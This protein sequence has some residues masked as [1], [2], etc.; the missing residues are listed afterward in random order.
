[1][2]LS[3]L[4]LV[5]SFLISAPALRAQIS[6]GDLSVAHANLEGISN[7]TQCHILG[8]K[9]SADKCLKCHTEIKE[10]IS[11]KKGYHASAD[12]NGKECFNCH[13][14]HNGRNFKLI[15]FDTQKFDHN[16]TGY[17]LSVPHSKKQCKDCHT[18][19]YITDL[20]I[21]EKKDSYLGLG[22]TCLNC[23]EDY[24]LKTLPDACLNCHVPDFFVP[25]SRFSHDNAK[26]ILAGKHKSVECAKCHKVETINDKKF[27]QFRGIQYTNCTSCHKDPHQGQFGQN[28]RQCHSEESF[29]LVQGM[30][31]FDHNKTNYK[32]EDKHLIVTC[33]SCHKTKF[34]DPLKH[35]HCTDCHTDYHNGQLTKNG[36]SPDCSQCHSLKGFTLFSFTVDQH[37]QGRFVLKGAHLAIP[38]FECHRKQE[39]WAFR[40][41]GMKCADCHKDI[42]Q[43][44]IQPKYYS[45][46][47][48]I[49]C[50]SEAS[51]SE[52]KFDHSVTD[53]RLTG[54]HVNVSC[55][56][57]HIKREA[58]Q[59]M[60]QK[61][62]G[63]LKSCSGCHKDNHFDQFEKNGTTSCE[64]CHD[65][66][67]W[68]ASKFDHS[69]TNFK[70]D[71][72]HIGVPCAKCHK[73]QQN[74]ENRYVLYKIKEY[75]CESCHS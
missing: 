56:S 33:K 13:S 48:C 24:H 59:P 25:A 68:K 73:E 27:Q 14:E 7:C 60:I 26:F 32:L 21:K 37:N 5:F 2:R 49:T 12:V 3:N 19:K 45:A 47:G 58:E 30:K 6:P 11:Q 66:G 8:D 9:V 69:K 29:Q 28:C 63:L 44:Y 38:C 40:D 31:D 62:T 42:H 61:F 57:C 65:T 10:R 50:H 1:M 43:A 67:N 64:D 22:T 4:L 55:A 75:K 39:K 18:P 74:G 72:K 16:L 51:W 34:T 23:H 15:H 17:T 53:F 70:L 54:A 36:I 35:E 20:K 71:G 46:S 52:V 41:I